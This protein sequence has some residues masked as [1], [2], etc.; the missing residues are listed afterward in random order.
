M[1]PAV[2]KYSFRNIT[3]ESIIRTWVSPKHCFL[4]LFYFFNFIESELAEEC[5]GSATAQGKMELFAGPHLPRSGRRRFHANSCNSSPL[6]INARG[7]GR[8]MRSGEGEAPEAH[9]L[10]A[11]PSSPFSLLP[12][13]AQLIWASSWREVDGTEH[14]EEG[15][16]IPRRKG[17]SAP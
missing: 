15:V 4:F 16:L 9:T 10:L 13:R 12:S 8:G 5:Q 11:S 17:P 14:Q 3:N 7:S 2:L 1:T 6:P